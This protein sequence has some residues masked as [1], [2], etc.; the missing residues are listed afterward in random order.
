MSC[1]PCLVFTFI[2][3]MMIGM[4]KGR[5]LE[6]EPY[7][8]T[9]MV[10]DGIDYDTSHDNSSGYLRISSSSELDGETRCQSIYGFLPC[11][12]TMPE[13]VFLMIMYMYLMMVGEDWMREGNQA[14]FKLLGNYKKIGESVYRVIMALPRIVLVV[15]MSL[16]ICMCTCI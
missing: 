12:D 9:S 16:D 11:A 10:S 4:V 2:M 7:S 3:L 14:L 8:T 13:G 1:I 5:W 15:G 6:V